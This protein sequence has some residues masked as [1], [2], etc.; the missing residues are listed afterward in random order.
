MAVELDLKAAH[1]MFGLNYIIFRPHNVYGPRQNIADK[2]RNAVGI[3]MNQILRGEPITIFGDGKQTRGF[4][5]IS[6]VAALIAGSP[7]FPAAYN[8]VPSIERQPA[9]FSLRLPPVDA[10]VVHFG[11][12]LSRSMKHLGL[13]GL[14][15]YHHSC[16]QHTS[17]YACL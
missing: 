6:D 16:S 5:Y 7:A 14:A 13:A 11:D 1:H 2:F 3:F 8:E 17:K 10:L 4:S 12:A 9:L 15:D